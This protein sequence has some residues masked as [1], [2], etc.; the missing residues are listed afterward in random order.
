MRKTLHIVFGVLVGL[1]AAMA[2]PVNADWI[3]VQLPDKSYGCKDIVTGTIF[4]EALQPYK[5]SAEATKG[6]KWITAAL[7][8]WLGTAEAQAV[9]GVIR[10]YVTPGTGTV[11]P[12]VQTLSS[13]WSQCDVGAP[14]AAGS[15]FNGSGTMT[16]TGTGD[17]GSNNNN[18]VMVAHVVYQPITGPVDVV[19]QIQSITGSPGFDYRQGGILFTDT[20]CA[21][22][23][24]WVAGS[25]TVETGS[26]QQGLGF[27]LDGIVNGRATSYATAALGPQAPPQWM[28][29][30]WDGTIA[31]FYS[32]SSA[33]GPWTVVDSETRAMSGI[34]YV[35]VF[36]TSAS[37]TDTQLSTCKFTE[38][39]VTIPVASTGVISFTTSAQTVSE[40]AGSFTICS[41]RTNGTSGAASAQITNTGLGT[42]VGADWTPGDLPQ[43]L[44]WSAGEGSQKCTTAIHVTNRAGTQG[45][46]TITVAQGSYTGSSSG[47]PVSQTITIQDVVTV[48][49]AKKWHP[50]PFIE[51]CQNNSDLNNQANRFGQYDYFQS[52]TQLQGVYIFYSWTQLET[53]QGNY[54]AGINLVKAEIAHLRNE[55][56]PLRL[57]F[58]LLDEP[59]SG[60]C[61]SYACQDSFFPAY[62]QGTCLAHQQ[63]NNANNV[64]TVF[65]YWI[66]SCA[67]AAANLWTALGAG[68]DSEAYLEVVQL[69]YEQQ[70]QSGP[71]CCGDFNLANYNA[72]ILQVFQAAAAAFPHTNLRWNANWGIQGHESNLVTLIGYAKALGIG[73]GAQDACS[74]NPS[75]FQNVY[76]T[77]PIYQDAQNIFAGYG[78]YDSGHNPGT[79]TDQRGKM[80]S[81]DGVET[82]E[83]G[84]AAVCNGQGFAGYAPA[85]SAAR[86]AGY[87]DLYSEYNAEWNTHPIVY[88][89]TFTGTA[90]QQ[91]SV[92]TTGSI[93]DLAINHPMTHAA[94]PTDYDTLFGTGVAGTGCNTN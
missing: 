15:A 55:G 82:S 88:Y 83:L 24:P 18:N 48:T 30:N 32:G 22:T 78:G 92:G 1:G 16:V 76:G 45:A 14:P 63:F 81:S 26:G 73:W 54:T 37:T 8:S 91:W 21:G 7:G 49:S 66:P 57:I 59:N 34:N 60:F 94:C 62:L 51:C 69:G 12:P 71:T 89:N 9:A 17:L 5:T 42:A 56:H 39:V 75:T 50:G 87:M 74:I 58:A 61:Q 90:V 68:L 84:Y 13:P 4:P 44:N 27:H 38:P 67:T 31:T 52:F 28:R 43:T 10:G 23:A 2:G 72:G 29:M 40:G 19:T 85:A 33:L 11:T 41:T 65:K 35:G 77:Y 70:L 36:C 3:K 86:N 93:W 47:N 46:R 53:S 64:N 80:F 6:C 25:A 20:P 79:Y